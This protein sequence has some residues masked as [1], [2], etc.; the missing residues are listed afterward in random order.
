MFKAL[1]R[2]FSTIEGT[3][4]ALKIHSEKHQNESFFTIQSPNKMVRISRELLSEDLQFIKET[5]LIKA[6]SIEFN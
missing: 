4:S 2:K 3:L 1:D 6:L 5:S